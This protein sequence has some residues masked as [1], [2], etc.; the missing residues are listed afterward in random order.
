MI[1]LSHLSS[2]WWQERMVYS[3]EMLGAEQSAAWGLWVGLGRI[4]RS[5]SFPS[6]FG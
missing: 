4:G 3:L 2:E 1:V 6:L 5:A